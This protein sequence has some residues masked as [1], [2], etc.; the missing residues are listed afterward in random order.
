MEFRDEVSLGEV[1]A[2]YYVHKV[3][4]LRG[5]LS[6]LLFVLVKFKDWVFAEIERRAAQL[7]K[8]Y[9]KIDIKI[10]IK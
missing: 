1:D 9:K 3:V 6:L 4:S 10:K 8:R 7:H 5:V 2:M